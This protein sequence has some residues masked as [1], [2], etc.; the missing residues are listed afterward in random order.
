MKAAP[1]W[2]NGYL[3]TKTVYNQ[4]KNMVPTD[5]IAQMGSPYKISSFKKQKLDMVL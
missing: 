4:S 5:P 3:G 2:C 1:N